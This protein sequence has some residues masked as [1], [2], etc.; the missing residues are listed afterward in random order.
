MR[1]DGIF[2]GSHVSKISYHAPPISHHFEEE[3]DAQI[4]MN[5]LSTPVESLAYALFGVSG[6]DILW[7]PLVMTVTVCY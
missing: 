5:V 4:I 1:W 7:I 2:N 3:N 6:G